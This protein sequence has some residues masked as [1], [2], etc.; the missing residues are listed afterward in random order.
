MKKDEVLWYANVF[1]GFINKKKKLLLKLDTE[2]F[3]PIKKFFFFCLNY[4]TKI[5]VIYCKKKNKK[6]ISYNFLW[7]FETW[8]LKK[9]KKLQN[10]ES[11]FKKRRNTIELI[12]TEQKFLLK[13]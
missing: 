6:K 12:E 3:V 11:A 2:L 1:S 7:K 4:C 9:K 8:K 13:N 10:A 5:S